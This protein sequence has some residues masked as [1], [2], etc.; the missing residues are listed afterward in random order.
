MQFTFRTSTPTHSVGHSYN[1]VLGIKN[2][3]ASRYWN[4]YDLSDWDGVSSL[5]RNGTTNDG[6][7]GV[8]W[9]ELE[10]PPDIEEQP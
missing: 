6:T 1:L 9:N 4:A 3:T 5:K 2:F 10:S 7:I 8:S